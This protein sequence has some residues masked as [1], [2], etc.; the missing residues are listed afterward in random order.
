MEPIPEPI[1]IVSLLIG[2]V[3]GS[4]FISQS[5]DGSLSGLSKPMTGEIPQRKTEVLLPR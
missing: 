5:K 4:W 1:P 3:L 2:Q